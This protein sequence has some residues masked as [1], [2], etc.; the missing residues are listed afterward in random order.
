[1]PMMKKVKDDE[2]LK[3][4]VVMVS[5]VA[6]WQYQQQGLQYQSFDPI[7][8][9]QLEQA[10]QK[11]R[12]D[13]KVNVQG[14]DYTV[15][16][17]NGPA[18]NRKGDALQI[19]RIDKLKDEVP[20]HWDAMP[21]NTTCV[22]VPIHEET[23]EYGEVLNLFQAS[24][25]QTVIKIDRIQNPMFWKSLQVK[26]RDIE[27]RN[28][29]SNNERRLF[30]GTTETI[31][32][33]INENGFNR[34]YAGKNAAC[35]GNGTY[36]A[37]NANYSAQDTYSRPNLK[38]E[39]CMYLCQVLTGDYTLG[40]KNMV[41]PPAKSNTSLQLYDSVVDNMANPNMFIIFHDVQAYPEYLITFK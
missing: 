22:A 32:N 5:T 28:G 25:K 3:K 29:H 8:N 18:T 34:A 35:F 17:P 23:P 40:K 1:M 26:K 21:P 33:T 12:T 41:V 6:D 15:T 24:C 20:E 14:Q 30:H 2:D 13:V 9:F 16:L 39:K 27:Q 4:Y 19:R 11:K 36:F 38:G 7:T 31:V 10:M 37:V